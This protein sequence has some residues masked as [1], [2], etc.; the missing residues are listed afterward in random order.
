MESCESKRSE[1]AF[2]EDEFP[3]WVKRLSKE[4]LSTFYPVAKLSVWS[5]WTAQS[6]GALLGHQLAYLHTLTEL[7]GIRSDRIVR[8]LDK[9]AVGRLASKLRHLEDATK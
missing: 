8:K 7:P 1:P 2:L 9:K 4:L 6:L 5:H 3:E